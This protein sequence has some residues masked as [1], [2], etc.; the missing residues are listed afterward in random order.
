MSLRSLL[1]VKDILIHANRFSGSESMLLQRPHPTWPYPFFY[2]VSCIE[3]D[4]SEAAFYI[5]RLQTNTGD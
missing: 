3:K 4:L 5:Y 1:I 2:R